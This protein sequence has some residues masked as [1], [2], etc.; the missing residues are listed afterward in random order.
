MS[1]LSTSKYGLQSVRGYCCVDSFMF[2]AAH[3][4]GRFDLIS[5][6]LADKDTNWWPQGCLCT[7]VQIDVTSRVTDFEGFKYKLSCSLWPSLCRGLWCPDQTVEFMYRPFHPHVGLKDSRCLVLFARDFELC[8]NQWLCKV[9]G[10]SL[11]KVG[12]SLA[13]PY[14]YCN[15]DNECP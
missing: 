15:A 3:E 14:V 8:R 9:L 1:V 7:G 5:T 12:I 10:V 6:R 4:S 2:F 11:L 13:R